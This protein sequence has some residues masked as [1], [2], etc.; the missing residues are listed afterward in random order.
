VLRDA[1][2]APQVS[3]Y[4]DRDTAASS[5]STAPSTPANRRGQSATAAFALC[6]VIT[7]PRQQLHEQAA[8]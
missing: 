6:R 7:A 4:W 8:L 2:E 1:K 5:E 3:G